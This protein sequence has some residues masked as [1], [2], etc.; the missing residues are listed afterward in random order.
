MEPA[1]NEPSQNP[2]GPVPESDAEREASAIDHQDSVHPPER[3]AGWDEGVQPS[4]A[5]TAAGDEEAAIADGSVR[6]PEELAAD[7]ET[8]TRERYGDPPHEG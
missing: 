8:V 3:P 5:D 6:N 4:K 2:N 1:E 7:A